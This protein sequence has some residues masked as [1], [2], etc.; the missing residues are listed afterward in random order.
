MTHSVNLDF[1][2]GTS[3]TYNNVP[4][5]VSPQQI[6]ERAG[7]DFPGRTLKNAPAA[8]AAA[9]PPPAAAPPTRTPA[10]P[11]FEE[12]PL[13]YDYHAAAQAGVQP[14]ERGHLPD[15]FKA[16]NHI[17]FS[18]DSKYSTPETPG[19][20][21]S[22]DAAGKWTYR[23]SDYV[24]KQHGP[25]E[26][27]DYFS[28]EER[29][30]KLA[31]PMSSPPQSG[32]LPLLGANAKKPMGMGDYLKRDFGQLE[33]SIRGDE[34]ADAAKLQA[35]MKDPSIWTRM[36][37][38][39]QE[40]QRIINDPAYAQRVTGKTF[41]ADTPFPDLPMAPFGPGLAAGRVTSR[42]AA[43][44]EKARFSETE[45]ARI[46]RQSQEAGYAVPPSRVKPGKFTMGTIAESAAGRPE[47]A[48]RF[49]VKNQPITNELAVEAMKLP[50]NT[51]LSAK[52]FT[53]VREEAGKIYDAIRKIDRLEI[54]PE[55]SKRIGALGAEAR[56]SLVASTDEIDALQKSLNVSSMTPQQALETL[57]DLR[58]ISKKY[59]RQAETA[60]GEKPNVER[61][62]FVYREAAQTL[63]DMMGQNV[64]AKLGKGTF[65][66]WLDARKRIAVSHDIEMALD[67][68]GNVDAQM[69][70][71]LADKRP[72]TDEL[73][74]IAEFAQA[75]GPV[76]RT[77][78]QIG[79]TTPLSLVDLI[80]G[81][82]GFQ[83]NPW[84]SL[85]AGARPLTREILSTPLAQRLMTPAKSAAKTAQKVEPRMP[86]AAAE[87]AAAVAP[88][89]PLVP[90][91]KPPA[92]SRGAQMAES[93]RRSADVR[94]PP[95][96]PRGGPSAQ[97]Q[98]MDSMNRSALQRFVGSLPATARSSLTPEQQ[99]V[100]AFRRAAGQ[101]GMQ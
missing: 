32:N 28:R 41:E 33:Q 46:A 56:Q 22:K 10:A 57:R 38:N 43:L 72:F 68:H 19:G 49:A 86:P 53:R 26:L 37:Y 18:T 40:R 29:D 82:T 88:R 61:L 75:F 90:P 2:D 71:K 39:P 24:L 48:A 96:I 35:Q 93:M 100:E 85:A 5:D 70:G 73:N 98:M 15:T 51:P 34:R 8:P 65:D 87:E 44:A 9:T 76:A 42:A 101:G 59:F 11:N 64:E 36:V 6:Q 20:N 14:D 58:S 45:L 94:A 67:A 99:M 23:P 60:A 83:A 74:T 12:P 31:L 54:P 63:E 13:D 84:G 4:D 25:Q 66:K 17:T 77:P 80:M 50:K 97:Q 62:A 55:Y 69:I 81:I 91:A 78:A 79:G 16:T 92:P 21:W 30:A 95:P 1:A 89:A 47:T 3:H 27:Q 52:V 7:R